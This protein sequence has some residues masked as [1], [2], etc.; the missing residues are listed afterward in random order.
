[1]SLKDFDSSRWAPPEPPERRPPPFKDLSFQ[2]RVHDSAR[3]IAFL[4]WILGPIM[5]TTYLSHLNIVLGAMIF[6]AV[7]AF[8]LLLAYF[9]PGRTA[10][11]LRALIGNVYGLAAGIAL[12]AAV[13]MLFGPYVLRDRFGIVVPKLEALE[14]FMPPVFL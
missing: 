7:F 11:V 9:V 4:G 1:M 14:P 13:I 12:F 3:A 5:A 8:T 2:E 6:F 10:G